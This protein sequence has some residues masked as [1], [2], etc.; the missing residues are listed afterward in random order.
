MCSG[1]SGSGHCCASLPTAAIQHLPPSLLLSRFRIRCR[2]ARNPHNFICWLGR[3]AA[4][5]QHGRGETFEIINFKTLPQMGKSGGEANK[6]DLKLKGQQWLLREREGQVLGSR[7]DRV[8][9]SSDGESRGDRC[10][11]D[12]IAQGVSAWAPGDAYFSVVH[13]SRFGSIPGPSP[14]DA[15]S[16]FQNFCST[17]GEHRTVSR[18]CQV[19]PRDQNL[20]G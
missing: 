9:H 8:G 17:K 3:Q 2:E 16:T 10:S 20:P 6:Q 18:H 14:L 13:S 19:S 11:F 15:S 7:L 12:P 5:K 1:I 4:A